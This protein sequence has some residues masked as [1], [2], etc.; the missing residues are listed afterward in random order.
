MKQR[1][2]NSSCEAHIKQL[3]H[4]LSASRMEAARVESNMADALASK[5]SEI[6]SLVS[7]MDAMKKQAAASEGKLASVQVPFSCSFLHLRVDKEIIFTLCLQHSFFNI[8]SPAFF[9]KY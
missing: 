7:S 8:V 5:N 2:R 4:D 9:S 1:E 6:E 3:Q